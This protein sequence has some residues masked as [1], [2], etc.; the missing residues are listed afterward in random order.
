MA[1][2]DWEGGPLEAPNWKD[3]PPAAGVEEAPKLKEGVELSAFPPAAKGLLNDD[4]AEAL[5]VKLNPVLAGLSL[6]GFAAPKEVAGL[7]FAAG[8]EAP[9]NRLLEKRAGAEPRLLLPGNAFLAG[10]ASSCF[11][12]LPANI[13][14]A[15]ADEGGDLGA[16]NSGFDW[17]IPFGLSLEALPKLNVGVGAGCE[18]FSSAGFSCG[19]SPADLAAPKM[20]ELGV[21]DVLPNMLLVLGAGFA[22]NSEDVPAVVDALVAGAPNSEV[23]LVASGAASVGLAPKRVELW[24]VGVADCSAGL[25]GPPKRLVAGLGAST[26]FCGSDA[27]GWVW[28]SEPAVDCGT[29]GFA[30]KIDLAGCESFSLSDS[31]PALSCSEDAGLVFSRSLSL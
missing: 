8:V 2:P 26:A 28:K 24:V 13:E 23:G 29:E 12:G 30:P 27:A 4:P 11:I 9:P 14:F 17:D 18:D 7:L 16:P 25:L 15:G 6:T 19:V 5:L 1:D 10:D 3:D 31:P 22:P 21:D 20:F